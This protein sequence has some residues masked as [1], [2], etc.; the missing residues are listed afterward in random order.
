MSTEFDQE[1][2]K[3]DPNR[4]LNTLPGKGIINSQ[5]KSNKKY[6]LTIIPF[7]VGLMLVSVIKNETRHLQKEIN[8]LQ[9]S[10]NTLKFDLHQTIL[11]HDVITSPDNISRL[12]KEYLEYDF[13]SYKKSQIKQL[14][15][16]EKILVKLDKKINEDTYKEKNKNKAKKIKIKIE[17]KIK[18]TKTELRKL[19]AL[20]SAPE[21]L[22]DELKIQVAKKIKKK[23]ND[24]KKLY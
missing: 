24:L 13:I 7:V 3:L 23:K 9:T 17:E 6:F 5:T 8:L 15:K 14:N 4:W 19:Q 22:P 16:E 18:K 21:K 10:I 20:Y 12:A 11:D 1:K 2:Y